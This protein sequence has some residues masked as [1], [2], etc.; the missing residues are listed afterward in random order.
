MTLHPSGGFGFEGFHNLF[1]A[2]YR[3]GD[4]EPTAFFQP[5]RS[6]DEALRLVE[7]YQAFLEAC[8]GVAVPLA[9]PDDDLRN[10]HLVRMED[11]WTLIFPQGPTL[12]GVREAATPAQAK[13]LARQLAAR[14]ATSRWGFIRIRILTLEGRNLP[15]GG[16]RGH[17]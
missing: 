2:R 16:K 8:G 5:C 3:L 4:Q 9:P 7:D 6:F 12:G 1:A 10:G 13:R 14:L 11:T 17:P 15:L